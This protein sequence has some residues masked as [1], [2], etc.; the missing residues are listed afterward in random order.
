MVD[1]QVQQMIEIFITLIAAFI[2]WWQTRQ[3]RETIEF[4]SQPT[5][6]P[7]QTLATSLPAVS[8]KMSDSTKDWI[9][10]GESTQDKADILHQVQYNEDLGRTSYTIGYSKG[11][12]LIEY[13]LI[14]SSGR[15]K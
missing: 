13:G 12:Y 4:Y 6:A 5:N 14:K 8:W 11:F 3:K 9:T 7:Q 15:E 10:S 1:P 2:A